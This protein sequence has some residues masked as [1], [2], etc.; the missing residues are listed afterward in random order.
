VDSISPE[1]ALVDEHLDSSARRAL[2]D[3]PD[4]LTSPDDVVGRTA[5]V[6][7]SRLSRKLVGGLV[8]VALAGAVAVFALSDDPDMP[9]GDAPRT[10][11]EAPA[12]SDG[13]STLRWQPVRGAAYYNV[14]FWRDGT[15]VLDLWPRSATVSVPEG[16]LAPGSYQ[17]FVYPAFGEKGQ[18]KYGKVVARGTLRV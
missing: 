18:P 6:E 15:R 12:R 1:L 16:R 17:W 2:P 11:A 5:T 9:R 14:I 13:P 8:L 3:A 10:A 4:C 7:R